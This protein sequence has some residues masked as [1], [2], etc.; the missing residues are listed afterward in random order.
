MQRAWIPPECYFSEPSEEYNVFRDR[1]WYEDTNLSIEANVTGLESG[2]VT[3]AY[4]RY[5]HDEHCAYVLRKLA[6]AVAL[7]RPMINSV[8]A[9]I[10]HANHCAQFISK[11]I[12]NSYNTSFL[13]TD[14]SITESYLI[15]EECVPLEVL[16]QRYYVPT[17][18]SD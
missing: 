16:V 5:W 4:T 6:L 8:P 13:E 2:D 7:R 12:V 3:L 14:E 9:N 11:R 17:E 1:V 10:H 15:F 18:F